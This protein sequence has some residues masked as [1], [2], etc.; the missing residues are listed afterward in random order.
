MRGETEF[1]FDKKNGKN[2]EN[3]DCFAL[4][5]VRKREYRQDN[6]N[7]AGEEEKGTREQEPQSVLYS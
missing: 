1:A 4:C 5:G 6:T 2:N 7:A 3:V